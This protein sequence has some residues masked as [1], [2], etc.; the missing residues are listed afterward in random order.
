MNTLGRRLALAAGIAG[1]VAAGQAPELAQQYRQRLG[2]AMEELR[3]IVAQF[4]DDATR[5]GMSRQEA[6]GRYRQSTDSF[7][8]DRGRSMG[9]T[10]G[11][12]EALR[13]QQARFDARPDY[14]LPVTMLSGYD[15]RLLSGAWRDYQP[16]LPLTPQGLAWTALGF[17]LGGMLIAIV[18]ALGGRTA[19]AVRRRRRRAPAVTPASIP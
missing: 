15:S 6:L 17:V 12:Y 1:A 14:L 19:R 2:G 9:E 8:N 5:N 18:A 11:R 4:D 10:I 13:L 3:A 7:F 16:A